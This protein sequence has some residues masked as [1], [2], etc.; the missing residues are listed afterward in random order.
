MKTDQAHSEVLTG[1]STAE[2]GKDIAI[3]DDQ[4]M[5]AEFFTEALVVGKALPGVRVTWY[6]TA[7]DWQD[8]GGPCHKV[9]IVDYDMPGM[10]GDDAIPI[11]RSKCPQSLVVGWSTSEGRKRK[12]MEAGAHGF[13]AKLAEP[14]AAFLELLAQFD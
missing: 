5:M 10:M 12:M 3:I 14:V 11:I 1:A 13:I 8:L 7:L 6:P 2:G 4:K 9:F